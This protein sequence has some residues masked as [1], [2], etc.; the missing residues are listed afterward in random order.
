MFRVGSTFLQLKLVLNKGVT[1]E[2]VSMGTHSSAPN[3]W[4][5]LEP[6]RVAP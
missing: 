3:E 4:L 5:A 6:S 2:N 1:K